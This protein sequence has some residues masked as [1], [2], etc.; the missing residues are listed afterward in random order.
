MSF[1]WVWTPKRILPTNRIKKFSLVKCI[2][3][4]GQD[5]RCEAIAKE[6]ASLDGQLCER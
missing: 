6:V 2:E 5:C 3:A 4:Q 1:V